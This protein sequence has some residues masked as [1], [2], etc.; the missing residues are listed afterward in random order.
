MG[1]VWLT[2]HLTERLAIAE[3]HRQAGVKLDLYLTYR[4][5]ELQ[6]YRTVSRLLTTD[7]TLVAALTENDAAGVRDANANLRRFSDT[8]GASVAFLMDR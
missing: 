1:G 6:R 2:Q 4:R 8:V 3:V 7:P 5:S